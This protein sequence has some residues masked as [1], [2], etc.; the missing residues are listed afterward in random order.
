MMSS[1]ESIAFQHPAI[2]PE[3]LARDHILSWSNEGELVFDPMCGSGTT[4]KMA[5]ILN[6]HYL[7]CD[8]SQEYVDIANRR[9]ED[10]KRQ[11]K[12]F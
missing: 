11:L 5:L 7:G 8:I 3:A 4:C 10:E 1:C 6:R 2:F 12:L 9:I